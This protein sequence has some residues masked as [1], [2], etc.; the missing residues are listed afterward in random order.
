MRGAFRVRVAAASYGVPLIG[1]ARVLRQDLDGVVGD[2]LELA[3]GRRVELIRLE[4]QLAGRVNARPPA[5]GSA[6]DVPPTS[7]ISP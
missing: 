7:R 3:A 5:P 6:P 4:G 2:D 1:R